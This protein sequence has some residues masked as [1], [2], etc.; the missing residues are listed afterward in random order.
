MESPNLDTIPKVTSR[1]FLCQHA[2]EYAIAYRVASIGIQEVVTRHCVR[3]RILLSMIVSRL[4][5]TFGTDIRADGP[6]RELPIAEKKLLH[7]RAFA[8]SAQG[9][10]V[11]GHCTGALLSDQHLHIKGHHN[12]R[13]FLAATIGEAPCRRFGTHLLDNCPAGRQMRH[14]CVHYGCDVPLEAH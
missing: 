2:I 11:A 7:L 10:D 6:T 5:A 8:R 14:H 13:D 3:Q 4:A 12:V 9:E 1:P